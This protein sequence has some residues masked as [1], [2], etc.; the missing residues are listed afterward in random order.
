MNLQNMKRGETTEQ[1]KLFNWANNNL[2]ALPCLTL[3]YHVPNEGKRSNGAVLKAMGMKNGVPDVVLPVAR[4]NFHGLYLEMKYG[5]NRETKE[6][7]EFMELLRQQGYKTSVC[8]GFENAKEAILTYL[9]EENKPPLECCLSASWIY[10][11]CEGYMRPGSMFSRYECMLCDRHNKTRAEQ[12]IENNMAAAS[13][14]YRERIET[15]IANLSEGVAFGKT[16]L[17]YTLEMISKDLTLL[18]KRKALTVEQSAA[19]LNIAMEAYEMAKL[20]EKRK[21]KN[22]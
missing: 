21:S 6:Q 22:E 16:D 8:Y 17:E 20:A 4:K 15:D 10:E 7:K 19:V 1:I 14:G 5:K 12:I 11:K 9:Q 13:K 18:A 2:A 3:M